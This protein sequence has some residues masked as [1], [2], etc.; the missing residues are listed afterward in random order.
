[1]GLAPY[2][3]LWQD[4]SLKIRLLVRWQGI[5]DDVGDH[6]MPEH[7]IFKSPNELLGSCYPSMIH[8]D[9]P[10]TSVSDAPLVS[11]P[12]SFQSS[13]SF[14][15]Y[16]RHRLITFGYGSS[17]GRLAMIHVSNSAHI[18]VR[19]VTYEGLLTR[20]SHGIPSGRVWN[21]PTASLQHVQQQYHATQ[22]SYSTGNSVSQKK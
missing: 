20:H 11:S 5:V 12:L 13:P 8:T 16:D 6:V 3:M 4:I 19:L 14:Q 22:H 2:K 7:S 17:Q 15:D 18:D 9:Y 10:D 21:P 1:M